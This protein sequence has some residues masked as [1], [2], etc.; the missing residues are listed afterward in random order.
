MDEWDNRKQT[1]KA[2]K[3][4]QEAQQQSHPA[5]TSIPVQNRPKAPENPFDDLFN[6]KTAK[7]TFW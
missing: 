1:R 2:K 4:K 5:S 7:N 3:K 6:Y